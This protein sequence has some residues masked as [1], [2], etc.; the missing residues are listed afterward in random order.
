MIEHWKK[1]A[2]ELAGNFRI[3]K[4]HFE[5]CT[6]PKDKKTYTF[7]ILETYNW[8]NIIPLTPENEVVMVKQFRHGTKEVTLEIPGGACDL[9]DKNP[10]H[11][12]TRELQEETGY[13]SDEVSELGWVHP[14]PA[15]QTNK[16]YT[17][18]AKNCLLTHNQNLD[19]AEDI[20]VVKIPLAE[21]PQKIRNKEI[22]HSLVISAFHFLSLEK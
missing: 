19:L 1:I 10:L 3:F 20:E 9:T 5:K 15:F 17:F 6:S 21:I 2:S 13:T 22:T 7:T 16:T 18:L 8:V 4:I 11:S 12:A 14:N